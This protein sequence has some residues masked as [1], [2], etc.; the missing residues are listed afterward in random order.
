MKKRLMMML[1][2]AVVSLFVIA[3]CGGDDDNGDDSGNGNGNGS[4]GSVSMEMGE[5]YFDPDSVSADAGSTLEI[6]FE[7]AGNQLH[8]FTIDD[9]GGERVHVEVAA[10]E[11]DSVTLNIPD[12]SGE[13]EFYCSVPGHRESGM[14]GTISIN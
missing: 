1:S 14:E 2:L 7:N 10:G 11:S 9:L 8:D 13:I 3:A 12:D 4:G 6:S 5:M